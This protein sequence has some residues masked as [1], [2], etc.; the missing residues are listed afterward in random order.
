[1]LF[2]EWPFQLNQNAKNKLLHAQSSCKKSVNE[3][4]ATNSYAKHREEKKR[5]NEWNKPIINFAKIR[6]G[7][8]KRYRGERVSDNVEAF[9]SI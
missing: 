5:I 2:L 4:A 3:Q 8:L 6:M 1:M 9:F 7:V